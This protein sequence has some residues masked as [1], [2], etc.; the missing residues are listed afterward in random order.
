[1]PK[2]EVRLRQ[3]TPVLQ[4][5]K[6]SGSGIRPTELKPALD[7]FLWAKYGKTKKELLMSC[8]MDPTK[9]EQK[10][11]N[12]RVKIVGDERE[13]PALPTLGAHLSRVRKTGYYSIEMAEDR[14]YLMIA[15][16]DIIVTLLSASSGLIE[17]LKECISEF[18]FCTN[19][20]YRKSKGFGS[21]SV[22]SINGK[23]KTISEQIELVKAA[24][25]SKKLYEI[26]EENLS[27]CHSSADFINVLQAVTTVAN[28][29]KSGI[30]FG[31][32]YDRSILMKEYGYSTL[33]NT[34]PSYSNEKRK[35]KE[36]I[37]VIRSISA[38]YDINHH[39]GIRRVTLPSNP[40]PVKYRFSRAM[41]GFAE[42][43]TFR[44]LNGASQEVY[45]Y[46]AENPK[47]GGFRMQS[48]LLFK[49]I[50]EQGVWRVFILMREV[51]EGIYNREFY[52]STYKLSDAENDKTAEQRIRILENKLSENQAVKL[53]T[54]ARNE[55]S[56]EAFMEC[57]AEY[58]DAIRGTAPNGALLGLKGRY[59]LI[60]EV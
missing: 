11:L 50:F 21:Y 60:E 47:N 37:P 57:V 55:F 9:P 54:P 1:M 2:I 25:H 20:G 16:G 52:F 49:P 17:L 30:N 23:V 39:G 29:M 53:T 40:S 44:I 24:L 4:R 22:V 36:E 33:G 6:Q 48:P 46:D 35:M 14:H 5:D 27:A 42:Q 45:V 28:I 18:F 15:Q 32:K 19:F 7:R 38:Q 3:H 13:V 10:A 34:K 12:Y 43:Y 41:L 51:P 8:R 56:L 26:T 31:G 58:S 59:P